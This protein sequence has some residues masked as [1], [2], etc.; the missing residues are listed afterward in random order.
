MNDVNDTNDDAV[1]AIRDLVAERVRA[2]KAKDPEPLAHQ[3]ADDIITFDVLPPLRSHGVDAVAEKTQAWFDGYDGDID[4][5]VRE[6]AVTAAGD[7]GFCS[8]VYHVGGT[9]VSG[10]AVDM[11]CA[12]RSAAGASTGRGASSTTTSRCRSTPR[13]ARRSSDSSPSSGE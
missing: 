6:L 8:F 7:L 10:D 5:D 9:L 12:P 11:W 4:Y 3:Q 1:Q 2:V 13:R